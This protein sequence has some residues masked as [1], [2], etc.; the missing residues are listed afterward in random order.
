MDRGVQDWVLMG[1]IAVRACEAKACAG[2][3][4][5]SVRNAWRELAVRQE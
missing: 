1:R 5:E 4:L 2:A 3:K